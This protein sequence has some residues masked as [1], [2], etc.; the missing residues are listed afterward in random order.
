MINHTLVIEFQKNG[1]VHFHCL[2]YGS[3]V[4][5]LP[6]I[7]GYWEWSEPQGV[8]VKVIDG[9]NVVGY[10]TKYINKARA[11][12]LREDGEVRK[13]HRSYMWLYFFCVRLYNCRHHIRYLKV[14]RMGWTC[15]G[16]TYVG[17]G[18]WDGQVD[19]PFKRY[20][21]RYGESENRGWDDQDSL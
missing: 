13:V 10:V 4:A 7:Q 15:V 8:D 19:I 17:D 2:F 18:T 1:M 9:L 3:W 20:D 21:E 11:C 5:P 12:V 14:V 6:Q 16:L